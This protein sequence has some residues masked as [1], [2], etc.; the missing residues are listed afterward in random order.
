MT[1]TANINPAS[2]LTKSSSV[3]GVGNSNIVTAVTDALDTT[4]VH[5]TGTPK[6]QSMTLDLSNFSLAANQRALG[7]RV[8]LRNARDNSGGSTQDTTTWFVLWPK[9]AAKSSTF[10]S[11]RLSTTLANVT[12]PLIKTPPGKT[13]EWTNADLA[14]VAMVTQW[15]QPHTTP[16]N[17][18]QRVYE[19]YASIDYITQAV[20]TG[21][22]TVTNFTNNATP[23]VAWIFSDVDGEEQIAYQV[24]IFTQTIVSSSGFSADRSQVVWD[25]GQVRAN[26]TNADDPVP[27]QNGTTYVA[28]VR[29]AKWGPSLPK[30]TPL[31]WSPWSASAAFTVTFA[32]PTTPTISNLINLTDES[33]Y[34]VAMDVLAPINLLSQADASLE[35][36]STWLAVSNTTVSRVSEQAA[37]GALSLKMVSTAAGNMLARIDDQTIRVD[38]GQTY[39]ALA[40][41]RA[42]TTGRASFVSIRWLRQDG[43]TQI[44]LT[45][46]STI[47]STTTGFTQATVSGAAPQGAKFAQVQVQVNSTAAASE[48]HYVD[49]IDLH[50]GT[51]TSWTPGG[52]LNDQGGLILQRQEF[53]DDA[54]GP[55]QNWL[56]EQIAT[57]GT[58]TRDTSIGFQWDAVNT[59][60]QWMWLDRSLGQPGYTPQGS[61]RWQ[62]I[63]T[64]L[65]NTRLEFGWDFYG[66][67]TGYSSP[68]LPGQAMTW[69]V[70][71]W[72]DTGTRALT[73]GIQWR[74]ASGATTTTNTT[75]ITVTTT[76]QRFFITATA[77]ASGSVFAT[78]Y[79]I[80]NVQTPGPHVFIAKLGFGPGSS[81][82]DQFQPLGLLVNEWHDVEFTGAINTLESTQP[83]SD[84]PGFPSGQVET[85]PDYEYPSGRPV[86]YRA[87]LIVTGNQGFILTS[88]YGYSPIAYINP[89]Q[90]TV[91]SNVSDP[92]L[93]CVVSRRKTM[94][95]S[96]TEDSAI[97][98][99]IGA[100]AAPVK[101][102]DWV[103]GED[104]QID[105]L[106]ATEAQYARLRRLLASAT[107]LVINWAQGGRS[108]IL[109]TG[110]SL[111]ETMSTDTDWC[112]A[113]GDGAQD[114][115]RYVV[116]TINYLETVSPNAAM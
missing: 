49:K 15:V 106:L 89:P 31:W 101:I 19:A 86:N 16:Y 39:T 104:G 3:V 26:T 10:L 25:S 18:F 92:T 111:N 66:L 20:V 78:G 61:L 76:P 67:T 28:Y 70:W 98:H 13:T 62:V 96:I 38:A 22:P 32:P 113:N 35:S 56:S 79:L 71:L 83:A 47:T 91:L 45:N 116:A 34:G 29:V 94:T 6:T 80:D 107:V 44:S 57:A 112:D 37:D 14:K 77:P 54:R 90:R 87:Q 64:G 93:Q 40:S 30:S 53:L 52:M 48:G 108:F 36:S 50:A 68:T 51:G 102:R 81:S 12:G 11:I 41:F 27:L 65:V 58:S 88:P 55:A 33:S 109:I 75:S 9:T 8:H 42:Q 74:D 73:L 1:T 95:Y 4:Y 2:V 46:G 63:G 99:P 97:F 114:H 24:K 110:V 23:N 72:C 5:G 60:L 105:V 7:L 82:V 17:V 85:I 69:S 103:S 21:A 100:N 43:T 84:P 59:D 115:I